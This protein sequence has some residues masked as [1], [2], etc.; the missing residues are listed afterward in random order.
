MIVLYDNPFSPFARKVRMA[1]FWKDLPFESIDG[2]ALTQLD[3]LGSLNPRR[4]VPVLEDGDVRVTN[5]SDIIAYLDHRYGP[6]LALPADAGRR[7]IARNWER[8]ADGVL[9]AILHD[10]SIWM[11]PS[12]HRQDRPPPGLIESGQRDLRGI[13]AGLENALGSSAFICDELSIADLALYPHVSSL[14]L[15]GL[16][17]DPGRSPRVCGWLDR[18]RELEFVRRDIDVVRRGAAAK[19]GNA[20]ASPYESVKIAWRGDRLEWLFVNGFHDWWMNEVAAKR[21]VVPSSL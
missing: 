7:V 6:P 4:E 15:L 12:H 20:D 3:M 10:I 13:L 16:A 18:M 2:L 11:W 5:S 21:A 17:P 14:R 1:L 9:D 19:F 8:L